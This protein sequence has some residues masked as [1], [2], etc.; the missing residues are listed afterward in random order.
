MSKKHDDDRYF[1][2]AWAS[3][4]KTCPVISKAR[5]VFKQ[6]PEGTWSCDIEDGMGAGVGENRSGALIRAAYSVNM[7]VL[8]ELLWLRELPR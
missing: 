5:V 2:D 4:E 3:L 7:L 6:L 8:E 1:R